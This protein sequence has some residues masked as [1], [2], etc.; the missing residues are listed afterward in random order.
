MV[1]S[2]LGQRGMDGNISCMQSSKEDF[3]KYLSISLLLESQ[4]VERLESSPDS[5]INGG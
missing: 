5:S 3:D 4:S 1:P 2:K